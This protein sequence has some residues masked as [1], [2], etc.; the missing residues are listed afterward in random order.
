MKSF[1]HVR[2]SVTPWTVAYQVPPSMRF[3][4][5]EYWSGLPFPSPGDLSNRG[6]EPRSPALPADAL[7]S[8]PAGK[9][10]AIACPVDFLNKVSVACMA[11]VVKNPPA[12]AGDIR[13]VGVRRFPGEG[14]G[15]PFQYSCLEPSGLQSIGSQ[16]VR[17]NWSNLACMH[18]CN[19]VIWIRI[20]SFVH[21]AFPS[22]IPPTALLSPTKYQALW[23]MR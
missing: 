7:P 11:L 5:Q 15:N 17:H 12:N 21:P 6:I 2:L 3:S 13:D 16:R 10:E 14:H 8:E 1:S 4:R 19:I 20:L 23:I 22:V 18:A 9:P